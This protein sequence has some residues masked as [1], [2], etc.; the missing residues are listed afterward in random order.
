MEAEVTKDGRA[1]PEAGLA[2]MEEAW[3]AVKRRER[4][5]GS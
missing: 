5:G 1:L 2:A 4:R 3:V